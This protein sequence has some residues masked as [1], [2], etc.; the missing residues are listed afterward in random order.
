MA[1]EIPTVEI[2]CPRCG[3]RHSS[4]A[5]WIPEFDE[6]EVTVTCHATNRYVTLGGIDGG[7]ISKADTDQ[8]A[9][10]LTREMVAPED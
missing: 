6:V 2:V 5:I 4:T 10:I 8:W 1:T 3:G 9:V 7:G